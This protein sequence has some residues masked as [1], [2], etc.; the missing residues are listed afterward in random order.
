MHLALLAF[1]ALLLAAP[2]AA[3]RQPEWRTATEVDIL[4]HPFRYEPRT[5]RLRAGQP[6][7]LRFVGDFT[8]P[9]HPAGIA[10]KH[11]GDRLPQVIPGSEARLYFAGALYTIP[12]AFEAMRGA[13]FAVEVDGEERLVVAQDVRRTLRR[14]ADLP[15]LALAVR[16]AV[17][18]AHGLRV[19]AV[20]LLKP[21]SVPVTSSGK[22]QRQACKRALA[23][24]TLEALFV[25]RD[26]PLPAPADAEPIAVVGM[27]C[28]F[29]KAGSVD[30]YWR[31]LDTG[32]DAITEVPAERW[33]AEE[34]GAAALPPETRSCTRWG[35]FIDGIDRFDA[36]FFGISPREAQ[37]MDPQQRMLL[38]ATWH[39]L[40]DA[41]I[42]PDTLAGGDAGVFVGAM[43][44]D[45][46][47]LELAQGCG[48]DAHFGTGVQ[49]SILANRISY[50]LD[51]HGP[52]WTVQTACSSGL[53]AL[54]N[55]RAS[56]QR[57]RGRGP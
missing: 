57:N 17:A 16:A 38:Q 29:P 2:A 28:R 15:A 39:A 11:F 51:L 3:Q 5:I 44:H 23:E 24:G 13:A 25:W 31:L 35:G 47:A 34:D 52:S 41:G 4:L 54:H 21:A 53:V 1:A 46:E 32:A 8:G 6:V 56:L 30:A 55:A 50:W 26:E 40:E 36:A 10:M 49:A 48:P 43:T 37:G 14:Q 12:E 9:P 20:H 45:Y 18:E 27:A 19:H 7:V 33:P 42:A 22:V